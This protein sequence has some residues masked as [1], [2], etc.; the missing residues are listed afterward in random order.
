MNPTFEH[1][2]G[3][4]EAARL[5]LP[6]ARQVLQELQNQVSITGQ[7]NA[8]QHK[9]FSDGTRVK[10]EVA[11]TFNKIEISAPRAAPE[12]RKR[13]YFGGVVEGLYGDGL[14]I[15]LNDTKFQQLAINKPDNGEDARFTFLDKLSVGEPYELKVSAQ[16]SSLSQ[17]CTIAEVINPGVIPAERDITEAVV[18]CE[19]DTFDFSVIVSGVISGDA[20]SFTNTWGEAAD[21]TAGSSETQALGDGT[22]AFAALKDGVA[23]TVTA[24]DSASTYTYNVSF[25]GAESGTVSGDDVQVS[26]ACSLK[27]YLVIGTVTNLV[28]GDPITLDLSYGQAVDGT[29]SG[30][31]TLTATANSSGEASFS[32]SPSIKDGTQ[33]DVNVDDV[34]YYSG[35]MTPASGVG[36]IDGSDGVVN[37]VADA[38]SPTVGVYLQ[39]YDEQENY[40]DAYIKLQVSGIGDKTIRLYWRQDNTGDFLMGE[41]AV[42]GDGIFTA[43]ISSYRA[44]CQDTTVFFQKWDGSN[45]V[46]KTSSD[47]Y[48][49]VESDYGVGTDLYYRTETCH[50]QTTQD[51]PAIDNLTASIDTSSTYPLGSADCYLG[52]LQAEVSGTGSK[53]VT[54]TMW[55]TG[56]DWGSY[57]YTYQTTV[58]S[59]VGTAYLPFSQL[60]VWCCNQDSDWNVFYKGSSAPSTGESDVWLV[61]VDVT[62]SYGSDHDSYDP[63]EPGEAGCWHCPDYP[64]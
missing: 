54:F 25:G 64:P 18:S 63:C 44:H 58:T 13:R 22:A 20:V 15:D 39:K 50:T 47:L 52:T 10:V 59:D 56:A 53:T 8:V 36:T 9:K 35:S 46:T 11:P 33:Y 28:P 7:P 24:D 17:T 60:E 61:E 16:P 38:P 51:E 30:T 55:Y 4:E 57:Y 45:W 5:F 42:S 27:E 41:W 40:T 2:D 29:A 32:F 43:D 26:A 62:S 6:T 21:G 12:E 14:V 49:E 19:I 31:D 37:I 3:D 48:V 34:V 1:F 23:Y